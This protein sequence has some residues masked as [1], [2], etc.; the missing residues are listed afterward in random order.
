MARIRD[1]TTQDERRA[2]IVPHHPF[3]SSFLLFEL[4]PQSSLEDTLFMCLLVQGPHTNSSCSCLV[5]SVLNEQL[6]LQLSE[7]CVFAIM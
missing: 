3:F 2:H 6:R 5:P 4:D 7:V 1:Y